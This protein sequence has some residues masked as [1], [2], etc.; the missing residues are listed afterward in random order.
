MRGEASLMDFQGPSHHP[1]GE[2][3]RIIDQLNT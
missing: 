3:I 2:T 1:K